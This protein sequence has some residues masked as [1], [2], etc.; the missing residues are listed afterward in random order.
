MTISRQFITLLTV[1]FLLVFSVNYWSV[2]SNTREY[3]SLQ[4]QSHAQDA[5][6]SLGLSLNP[7]TDSNPIMESM[8]N[9]IFDGGNY[10]DVRLIDLDGNLV[11]NRH[12]DIRANV[13]DWFSR[14][15]PL[16]TPEAETLI[17][18]GWQQKFHLFVKSD[19]SYAYSDLWKTATD[20]LIWTLEAF[21]VALLCTILFT[22]L[23]LRPLRAV[24]KHANRICNRDFPEPMHVPRTR[25]LAQVVN[26]FNHMA[27]KVKTMLGNLN[28]MA[29]GLRSDLNTDKTTGLLNRCGIGAAIHQYEI[30]NAA[31][32]SKGYF[33]LI[34]LSGLEE[35]DLSKG[36]SECDGALRLSAE[37]I[38]HS[39]K[40]EPFPEFVFA[41][42][43]FSQFALLLPG[44]DCEMVTDRV[45]DL[46]HELNSRLARYADGLTAYIGVVGYSRKMD[47]C[48]LC[49]LASG[50]LRDAQSEI[51]ENYFCFV[52][53]ETDDSKHQSKRYWH[54]VIRGALDNGYMSLSVQ[55]ILFMGKQDEC[56]RLFEAGAKITDDEGNSISAGDFIFW[57]ERLKLSEQLD[58]RIIKLSLARLEQEKTMEILVN[59]SK[60]SMCSSSFLEWL[61]K[62][63]EGNHNTVPRLIL[64]L[65][66]KEVVAYLDKA[67]QLA[68]IAK[69]Y[70][71]KVA[72][73][74]F[75]VCHSPIDYLRKVKPDFIKID[76]SYIN[77][78][79]ND[80]ENQIMF[81]AYVDIA[82]GLDMK[83]IAA[84]IETEAAYRVVCKLGAN[85]VQGLLLGEPI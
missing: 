52:D 83:V 40:I 20:S 72:I 54:D 49:K 21:A 3:L 68:G 66:E 46:S 73:D 2:L 9:T 36:S 16:K 45:A 70:G 80:S 39:C 8:I 19:P 65:S 69:K 18:S 23:L 4:L 25:E 13:P 47:F 27:L 22:R 37:I 50:A 41:H 32:P 12:N 15:F 5:A 60:L 57:A 30:G 82:H 42:I 81:K 10:S 24:E 1:M 77:D 71:V 64:G 74:R 33:V 56:R 38:E 29:E 34:D 31:L 55:Q 63:L 14:L 7:Y 53:A 79:E 51:S 17:T 35:L 67:Q 85:A 84:F 28:E 44:A 6:T 48:H 59:I 43:G 75:G 62:T 58:Q 61:E 76:G 26:A 78:I 11:I